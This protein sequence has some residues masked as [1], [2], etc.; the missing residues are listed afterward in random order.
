[1]RVVGQGTT[2]QRAVFV[3]AMSLMR[4]AKCAI[5]LD[6]YSWGAVHRSKARAARAFDSALENETCCPEGDEGESSVGQ[7][8]SLHTMQRPCQTQWDIALRRLTA[9]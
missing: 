9:S 5:D 1:M 2:A 4:A 6:C 7:R 8:H 3:T